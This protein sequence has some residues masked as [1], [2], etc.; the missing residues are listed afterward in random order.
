[1]MNLYEITG[2][3]DRDRA[4]I[5]AP[6]PTAA[7]ELCPFYVD[8]IDQIGTVNVKDARVL[9]AV[10]EHDVAADGVWVRVDVIDD[11]GL[12]S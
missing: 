3:A 2:M 4:I 6:H 11:S 1:M 9:L 7:D 10:N 8:T 5:A 12:I